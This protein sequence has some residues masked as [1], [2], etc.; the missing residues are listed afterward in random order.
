MD[1]KMDD[2]KVGVMD[3]KKVGRSEKWVDMRGEML[4]ELM[5][6]MTVDRMALRRDQE[7]AE[8][9]AERMDRKLER[10]VDLM[11]KTMVGMR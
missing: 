10:W 7:R 3:T 8:P 11:D 6:E 1:E 4:D 9:M 5:D 2:L